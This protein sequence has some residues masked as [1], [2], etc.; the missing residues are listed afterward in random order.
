MA[1]GAIYRHRHQSYRQALSSI[2]EDE[3]IPYIMEPPKKLTTE[4]LAKCSQTEKMGKIISKLG[5]MCEKVKELHLDLHDDETGINARHVTVQTQSDGNSTKIAELKSENS[6]LKGVVQKQAK[7]LSILSGRVTQLVAK[8]MENNI[9]ITSIEGD[10]KKEDCKSK[11][12]EFLKSV[13]EIDAAEE[14]ILV[15]HRKGKPIEGRCRPML[16]RCVPDLKERILK[17]K[18]NIKEKVNSNNDK[19][20]INKQIPDVMAEQNKEI[21]E[22]IREQKVKD[23]ALPVKERSKI[24]IRDRT[25]YIDGSPV[26]KQLVVPQ[27]IELFVDKAERDKMDKIKFCVSDTASLNGSDFIGFAFKTGQMN[28]VRRAY[29]KIKIMHPSADHIV[30]AY[31]LKNASGH[32]DDDELSAGAKLLKYL[33][34]TRP[35]NTVIFVVR[36]KNGGNLGFTR[37]EL[38][39]QAAEQATGKLKH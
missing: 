38:F 12:L 27:P 8:S 6:I 23:S 9:T 26:Q 13:L 24:E 4:E 29:R 37:F 36:Y 19:Y 15:A 16:L 31:N 22:A 1:Q 20:Y 14:E 35:L 39:E 10:S 7:Q 18:M 2:A 5:E 21:R 30:A 11:A 34:D 25:V 28:E 32:Q 17:N 3:L 33:R